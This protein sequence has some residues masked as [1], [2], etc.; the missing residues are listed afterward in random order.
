MQK[1]QEAVKPAGKFHFLALIDFNG[2]PRSGRSALME[3]DEIGRCE[4]SFHC[5][6]SCLLKRDQLALRRRS[7]RP[8]QQT[9]DSGR[10]STMLPKENNRWMLLH[11]Q[12]MRL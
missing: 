9:N 11:R 6:S 4:V 2:K 10:V 8:R 7:P 5:D 3:A 1:S 12:L